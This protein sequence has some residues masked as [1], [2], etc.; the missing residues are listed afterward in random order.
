MTL[1]EIKYTKVRTTFNIEIG[2]CPLLAVNSNVR[3]VYEASRMFATFKP[4]FIHPT[5]N[6]TRHECFSYMS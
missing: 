2:L 6:K 1:P 4:V 5:V 3:L